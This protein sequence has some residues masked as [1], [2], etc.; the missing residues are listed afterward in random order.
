MKEKKTHFS[1]KGF[2]FN[3]ALLMVSVAAALL[4]LEFAVKIF[5]PQSHYAIMS[6]PWGIRHIPNASI[7]YYG[8]RGEIGRPR[9]LVPIHYNSKGLRDHE[10][11]YE[12]PA[13]TFRILIL[14]DSWAED[15]GSYL[16]NLHAKILEKKLNSAGSPVKFEV[17]NA[18]HYAFDNAQELMFFELEG[19]KYS[20]DIVFVFYSGDT[21]QAKYATLEDGKL[22]LHLQT[23]TFAQE[24][25]RAVVS[26]LRHHSDL[27][28]LLLDRMT[29]SN[30]LSGLMM[31]LRL[32]EENVYAAFPKDHPAVSAVSGR[33]IADKVVLSDDAYAFREVD[34]Q[35]YLELKNE[36]EKNGGKL[37]FMTVSGITSPKARWLKDNG[38]LLMETDIDF[39]QMGS[40]REEDIKAGR[41]DKA[42]DSHRFGYKRNGVV[43]QQML[44]FLRRNDL[45]VK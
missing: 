35:I 8:E 29:G 5:Y 34:K 22:K 4:F 15:M 3:L 28:T 19:K 33:E 17:I 10:Y 20:P 41:Y 45:L 32:K 16:D 14:G 13:G 2:L 42:L 38:F 26:F 30:L 12:K 7:A 21:A 1:I 11:G 36:V 27:G 24:V 31:K 9:G 37:V 23:Y 25:R 40:D 6:A 44:D 43:A 18:G 39:K